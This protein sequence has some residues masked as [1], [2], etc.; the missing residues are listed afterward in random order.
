MIRKRR[1]IA[2]LEF[3]INMVEQGYMSPD[4]IIIAI[5]NFTW[6][7]FNFEIGYY[8]HWDDEIVESEKV[9]A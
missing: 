3:C 5:N 2:M 1:D 4:E 6:K 9:E 8:L 7:F